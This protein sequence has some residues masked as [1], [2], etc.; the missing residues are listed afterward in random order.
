MSSAFAGIFRN[1]TYASPPVK[2]TVPLGST[3]MCLAHE[4][5]TMPLTRPVKRE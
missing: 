1:D 5:P 2:S 4:S 3:N